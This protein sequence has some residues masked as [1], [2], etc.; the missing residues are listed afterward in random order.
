MP[1]KKIE[2]T[3]ERD[4]PMGWLQLMGEFK[5]TMKATVGA[6]MPGDFWSHMRASHKERLLAVRSLI[7]AQIER[8]EEREARAQERTI[9]KISVQ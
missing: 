2:A 6:P 8:I 7:D 9:H 5:R 4:K 3:V 1:E